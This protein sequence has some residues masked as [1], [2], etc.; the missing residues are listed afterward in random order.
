M[1]K[2]FI[3]ER[4]LHYQWLHKQA[5]NEGRTMCIY[6]AELSIQV[7]EQRLAKAIRSSPVN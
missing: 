4:L 1:S 6:H 7:L 3:L 5:R 2:A